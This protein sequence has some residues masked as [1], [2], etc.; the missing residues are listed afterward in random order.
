MLLQLIL[1]YLMFDDCLYLKED[2][3][4]ILIGIFETKSIP[5]F[6]SDNKVPENFSYGEFPENF[7]HFQ[8]YLEAAMKRMPVL[9]E[10]LSLIHI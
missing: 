7:D 5:A 8:P 6:Q 3:G 9:G 1:S 10:V 2:V 4:K